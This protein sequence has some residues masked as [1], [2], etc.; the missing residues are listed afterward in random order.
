M[1]SG[2]RNAVARRTRSMSSSVRSLS[3]S[4]LI[5]LGSEPRQVSVWQLAAVHAHRAV[6]G[7]ASE[8]GH[9]LAWIEQ[10]GGIEG[11]LHGM[12]GFE[13]CRAELRTH[14]PELFDADAMLAGHCPADGDT[15]LE[16]VGA[17]ALGAFEFVVAA[18]V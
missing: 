15:G 6:I 18:G 10:A 12:E 14:R 8:R 3:G 4:A 13:F 2:V 17:E 5:G 7:A 11:A 1:R 9:G 16:D